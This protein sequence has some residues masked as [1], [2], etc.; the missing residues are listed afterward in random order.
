MKKVIRFVAITLITIILIILLAGCTSFDEKLAGEQVSITYSEV[1]FRQK[2]AGKIIC[3][4]SRGTEVTCTGNK[5]EISGGDDHLGS[6]HWIEVE[7]EDGQTGWI[8]ER[9]ID[10]DMLPW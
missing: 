8:V 9:A 6:D 7:L 4:L 5:C 2:P 3:S 10:P 1:N